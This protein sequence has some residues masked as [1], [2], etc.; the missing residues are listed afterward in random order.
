MIKA[1]SPEGVTSRFTYDAYGNIKTVK[2]GSGS[3]TIS[4]SAV[5]TANG[6]QVSSVTDAWARPPPMATTPR[7]A[8]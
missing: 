6:D 8:F 1:V 2:L 3:Q 5:Y 7:Q 4:A